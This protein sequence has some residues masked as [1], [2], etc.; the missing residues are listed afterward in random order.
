MVRRRVRAM[1]PRSV[2]MPVSISRAVFGHRNTSSPMALLHWRPS[3]ILAWPG[4]GEAPA[5]A[6]GLWTTWISSQ[7]IVAPERR[8]WVGGRI[9][10]GEIPG[11]CPFCRASVGGERVRESTMTEH[12]MVETNGIRLHVA[13]MGKG[14]AVVFCHGWPETSYSWRHQLPALAQAGFRALAPDMRGYGRSDAPEPIEAYTLLH[15]VGDMVGLLDALEIDQA[16]IV[17]HDWGAPVA[18]NAAL[19]RPDRIRPVVGRRA[20]Y[21]PPGK[22][23]LIDV[24]EKGG[25]TDFYMMYFQEPVVAQREFERDVPSAL[26][27]MLYS[28]SGN[29]PE[30]TYWKAFRAPGG[31]LTDSMFD[32]K[33]PLP[34]LSEQDLEI[35]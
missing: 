24:L 20:P 27:R 15:L 4:H 21:S 29:L 14:P 6:R 10:R 11:K 32:T 3:P 17:G 1:L 25:L 23:S 34:W 7:K 2:L 26:R 16:V 19:M 30:G 35:G 12:R 31:G 8:L 5:R 28:A 33:M 13:E 9:A 18:W 22:V